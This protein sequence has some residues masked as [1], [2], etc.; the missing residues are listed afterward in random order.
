[1]PSRP[2]APRLLFAAGI[3]GAAVAISKMLFGVAIVLPGLPRISLEWVSIPTMLALMVAC[4]VSSAAL[5]R[6]FRNW[7]ADVSPE[8]QDER[9]KVHR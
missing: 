8:H 2:L 6:V 7:A 1:M 9:E 3:G 5:S 4:L